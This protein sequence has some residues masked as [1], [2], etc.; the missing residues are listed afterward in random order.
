MKYT[1]AILSVVLAT[2]EVAASPWAAGFKFSHKAGVFGT[3][4]KG[5]SIP[6][7]DYVR[8]HNLKFAQ[9]NLSLGSQG[10]FRWRDHRRYDQGLLSESSRRCG[11]QQRQ[12]Q[13]QQALQLLCKTLMTARAATD[14]PTVRCRK[15]Q[16]FR[17]YL[18]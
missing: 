10:R 3:D 2:N 13:V 5:T 8:S 16:G 17:I 7:G 6:K 9:S 15:G 11:Q 1:P 14:I 12:G 4:V 18:G